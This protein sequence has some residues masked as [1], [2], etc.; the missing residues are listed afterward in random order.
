M[1]LVR[2]KIRLFGSEQ[3]STFTSYFSL[4][5]SKLFINPKINL[6]MISNSEIS[7]VQVDSSINPSS[8][9]RRIWVS[10]SLNEPKE[11]LKN[12]MNS[13]FDFLPAP[14]AIFDGIDRA[15]RLICEVKPK[16]SSV[17]NFSVMRY[18]DLTK[19]KLLFQASKF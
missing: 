7:S 15:E 9:E 14:S 12:C 18:T 1:F 3:N 5:Y 11:T 6:P 2:S 4:L 19:K 17:G 13:F 10:N 8:F 16:R